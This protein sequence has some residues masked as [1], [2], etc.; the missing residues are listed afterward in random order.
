MNAGR[1][2]D[3]FLDIFRFFNED[4][5]RHQTVCAFLIAYNVFDLFVLQDGFG[6]FFEVF[7]VDHYADLLNF[8]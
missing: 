8:F 2:P 7:E 5:S 1:I 4:R 6:L 3:Q